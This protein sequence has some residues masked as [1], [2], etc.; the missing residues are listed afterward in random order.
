MDHAPAGK[1]S[2]AHEGATDMTERADPGAQER[3][4]AE[5]GTR[6][7]RTLHSRQWDFGQRDGASLR[8]IRGG[9]GAAVTDVG[10]SELK[11]GNPVVL[12]LR[13]QLAKDR[14]AG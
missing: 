1:P 10:V 12:L 13:Y 11:S 6:S 14:E 8:R 5:P 9:D 2:I 4:A 7:R 3:G